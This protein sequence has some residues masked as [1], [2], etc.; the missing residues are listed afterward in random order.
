MNAKEAHKL[1]E[2]ARAKG[3]DIRLDKYIEYIE[4]DIASA[5]KLG[6][7]KFVV[8]FTNKPFKDEFILAIQD[9]F[10][11]DEYIIDTD[12]ANFRK[13]TIDWSEVTE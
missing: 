1:T 11:A 10:I 12:E 9:H 2:E 5:A 7:D 3:K 4:R 8:D 6:K 13:F